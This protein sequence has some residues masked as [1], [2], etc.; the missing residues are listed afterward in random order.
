MSANDDNDYQVYPT[1]NRVE[2]GNKTVT[3]KM[4]IGK[5]KLEK[6]PDLAHLVYNTM[7]INGCQYCRPHLLVRC[8]LCAVDSNEVNE[9]VDYERDILELRPCGI[10]QLN[11]RAEKWGS[12]TKNKLLEQQLERDIMRQMNGEDYYIQNPE[13]WEQ[14]AV[15]LKQEERQINE[16]FFQDPPK[17]EQCCYFACESP[18]AEKLLTCSG[19]GIVKYCCKDHQAKDWLWEHKGE[20]RLPDFVKKKHEAERIRHLAGDYN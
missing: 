16:E 15:R 18:D 3:L 4:S 1:S 5:A 12:L 11:E 17:I 20:C 19:C 10:R 7:V 2:K 14:H 13:K 8:H 9:E 6:N